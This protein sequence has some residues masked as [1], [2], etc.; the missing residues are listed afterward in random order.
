MELL[1]RLVAPHVHKSIP[2]CY[3]QLGLLSKDSSSARTRDGR[4][5]SATVPNRMAFHMLQALWM[6]QRPHVIPCH[7][8]VHVRQLQHVEVD[9]VCSLLVGHP[10]N[11]NWLLPHWSCRGL[12]H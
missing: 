11:P 3:L 8:L 7:R 5:L 9:H 1:R 2:F 4:A 12:N 10:I 6:K